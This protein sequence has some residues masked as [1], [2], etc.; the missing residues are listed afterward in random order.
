[1][2]RKLAFLA[3]LVFGLGLVVSGMSSPAR[4]SAFLDIGGRWDPTLAFVMGGGLLVAGPLFWLAARRGRTLDGGIL[5]DLPKRGID[6]RLIGGSVVFGIGWGLVGL[7]PGPAI[8]DLGVVPLR[9]LA[10][11]APMAV[12]VLIARPD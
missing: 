7:C 12:G 1:M 6:A 9:A 5:P 8:T 2:T 11:L 3:G 4:V 10:F